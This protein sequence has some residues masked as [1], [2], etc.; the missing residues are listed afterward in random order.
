MQCPKCNSKKIDTKKAVDM[1]WNEVYREKKCR[2]CGHVFYTCEFEVEPNERFTKEF[3]LYGF[4]APQGKSF[5]RV[6]KEKKKNDV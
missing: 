6:Y 5:G 3:A 4:K 2:G 1:P